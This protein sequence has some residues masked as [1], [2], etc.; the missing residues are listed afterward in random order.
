MF[1]FPSGCDIEADVSTGGM[2]SS[3]AL[4]AQRGAAG[5]AAPRFRAA[6]Q[7]SSARRRNGGRSRRGNPHQPGKGEFQRQPRK[8]GF[9]H[10]PS[11]PSGRTEQPLE[12][13]QR[14]MKRNPQ[15]IR[16]LYTTGRV[17]GGA[18]GMVR[19]LLTAIRCVPLCEGRDPSLQG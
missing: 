1:P 7:G 8:R 5:R 2:G 15:S 17:R 10:G 4:P 16:V 3:P 9:C 12:L 18:G 11:P 19:W 13:G 6:V 14:L